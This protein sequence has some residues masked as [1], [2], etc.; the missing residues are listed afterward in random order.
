M[1]PPCYRRRC[2]LMVRGSRQGHRSCMLTSGMAS[3]LK[4]NCALFP[5]YLFL[6]IV[7]AAN[8]VFAQA[9]ANPPSIMD[10]LN[11]RMNGGKSAWMPEQIST[12]QRLRDAAMHDPYALT[13]LR[14][15]TDNI[16]PRLSGSP[17]PPRAGGG[18][19]GETARP[20]A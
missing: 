19:G 5:L 6:G 11:A 20:A 10:R 17:Q 8:A 1:F 12:M 4:L 14:H 9:P 13:E 7:A 16:G 18:G 3:P 2:G 15:L